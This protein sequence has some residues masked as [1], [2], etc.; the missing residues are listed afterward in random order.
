[1]TNTW[2]GKRWLPKGKNPRAVHLELKAAAQEAIRLSGIFP[3][4]HYAIFECIGFVET[5]TA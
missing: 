3:G 1:M 5:P 2:N 4:E